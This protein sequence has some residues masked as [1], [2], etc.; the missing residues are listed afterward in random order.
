MVF[1]SRVTAA[2]RANNLPSIV[3]PVFNEIDWSAIIVP[4]IT[5]VVPNEAEVP[6]CQ[7]IFAA[8]A[9]PAKITLR[10]ELVDNVDA[11]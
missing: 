11:I 8:F 3:A 5:D 7:K 2:I 10:P 1:P 4:F 6:T 9:P